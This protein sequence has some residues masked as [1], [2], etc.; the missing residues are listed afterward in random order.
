MYES[1]KNMKNAHFLFSQREGG[2][3]FQDLNAHI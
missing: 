1:D 2:K 3:M